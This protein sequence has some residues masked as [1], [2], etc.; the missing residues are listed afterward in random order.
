MNLFKKNRHEILK[1]QNIL[2]KYLK[3]YKNMATKELIKRTHIEEFQLDLISLF[4][5]HY[6]FQEG[7]TKSNYILFAYRDGVINR[8]KSYNLNNIL[9]SEEY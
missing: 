7:M 3:P 5:N 9:G 4:K 2:N 1:D 6:K 8:C